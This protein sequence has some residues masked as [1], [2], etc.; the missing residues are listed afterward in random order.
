MKIIKSFRICYYIIY[1]YFYTYR[2]LGGIDINLT[3]FIFITNIF[4]PL[5]LKI[6]V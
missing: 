6:I 3:R 5:K 2:S 4:N 1:L